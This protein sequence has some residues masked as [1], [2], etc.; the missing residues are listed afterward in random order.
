MATPSNVHQKS[1]EFDEVTLFSIDKAV[2]D[3]FNTKHATNIQGRKVPVIFG[4]WERFATMQDNKQDDNLNRMRDPKGMLILP[5][6]SIRRGDVTYNVDRFI[7]QQADGSPRVQI[8]KRVAMSNFDAN[9][10]VP[11]DGP[12]IYSS[13]RRRSDAPVMEIT[14]IPWPDFVNVPYT[15][16]FW[17]SYV[18]HANYFN[19]RIWQDAYPTDLTY[20]GYYFYSFIDSGTNES[21]EDN[22][23]DEERIIRSSFTMTVDG[24][25][26]KKADANVTRTASK[27]IISESYIEAPKM[28]T[29]GHHSIDEIIA[30][31]RAR[32][33]HQYPEPMPPGLGKINYGSLNDPSYGLDQYNQPQQ[34]KVGGGKVDYRDPFPSDYGLNKYTE[35]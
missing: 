33:P 29:P 8:S 21:N 12:H 30:H 19:D 17:S 26:L 23:T 10:R 14:T 18:R 22:Y 3:W 5:L 25:I 7:Y 16:T 27:M 35:M 20:K 24:Y 4:S 9:R 31:D 34:A 1:I 15:I 11:F 28:I 6:I 13:S 32:A 2:Y